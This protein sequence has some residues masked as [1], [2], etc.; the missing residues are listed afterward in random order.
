MES[1][2]KRETISASE[3]MAAMVLLY[4]RGKRWAVA[5]EKSVR[6]GRVDMSSLCGDKR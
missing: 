2:S 5:V 1:F 3:A 6:L 4:A